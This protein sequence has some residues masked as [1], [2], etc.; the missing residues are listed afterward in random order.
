MD[1]AQPLAQSFQSLADLGR[2]NLAR[3]QLYQRTERKQVGKGEGT[4]GRNEVL[5]F[6]TA[7]LARRYVQQPAH[8]FARIGLLG[9]W[10][11]HGESLAEG[12]ELGVCKKIVIM[13]VA[14]T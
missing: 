10:S 6:P 1:V 8:F 2:G 14:F 5:L 12:R 3:S 7:Q 4:R 11:G 13:L 9:C